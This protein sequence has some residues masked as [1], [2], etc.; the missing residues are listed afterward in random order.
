MQF[1]QKSLMGFGY[2]KCLADLKAWRFFTPALLYLYGRFTDRVLSDFSAECPDAL[3]L[4]HTFDEPL[5]YGLGALYGVDVPPER[6]GITLVD[7]RPLAWNFHL[8]AIQAKFY[9]QFE[10]FMLGV[11][12]VDT[13]G[14]RVYRTAVQDIM[15]QDPLAATSDLRPVRAAVH[16]FCVDGSDKVLALDAATATLKV[17]PPRPVNR[18][19]IRAVIAQ[20]TAALEQALSPA[21]DL[22]VAGVGPVPYRRVEDLPEEKQKEIARGIRM[23]HDEFKGS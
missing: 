17:W 9:P 6:C 14:G 11:T 1:M 10:N 4:Q 8:W 20:D 21:L 16:V 22:K 19:Y 3:F 7:D 5:F 18:Q 2:A 23:Y 12:A 13:P 15:I